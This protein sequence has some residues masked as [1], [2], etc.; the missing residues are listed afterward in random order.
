MPSAGDVTVI[1]PAFGLAAICCRPVP[2][3]RA[4]LAVDRRQASQHRAV[5]QAEREEAAGLAADPG[6]EILEIFRQHRSL[7]H[8]GETAVLVS[9]PAADAEE[10]RALIGRRGVSASPI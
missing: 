4:E 5:G 10:R 2:G 3:D 6:V 8:A 1:S 7:D 9:A